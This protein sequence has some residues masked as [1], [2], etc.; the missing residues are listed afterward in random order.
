MW[1]GPCSACILACGSCHLCLWCCW[2]TGAGVHGVSQ[3]FSCPATPCMQ[4]NGDSVPAAGAAFVFPV[5]LPDAVATAADGSGGRE[6]FERAA[7]NALTARMLSGVD[8]AVASAHGGGVTTGEEAAAEASRVAAEVG[9][10]VR[11]LRRR[12]DVVLPVA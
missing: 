5:E 3:P 11:A 8:A 12:L 1:P 7:K 4:A 10:L 2:N 6:G 9:V